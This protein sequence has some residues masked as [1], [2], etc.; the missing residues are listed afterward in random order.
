MLRSMMTPH[1]SG[2]DILASGK[3]IAPVDVVNEAFVDRLTTQLKSTYDYVLLDLP[4]NWSPWFYAAA[5]QSSALLTIV[6][7]SVKSADGSRRV[8]QGLSDLGIL[9]P[10][11]IPIANRTDKTP[12]MKRRIQ[13]ITDILG[14][15]CDLLIR[16]DARTAMAASD[17]GE[18]AREVSAT[19]PLTLDL[20]AI[21]MR[22]ASA[23]AAPA[24]TSSM[25]EGASRFR[26]FG[27]NT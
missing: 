2:F 9:A 3:S 18:C 25:R 1:K 19:A 21:A 15:P 11:L 8:V 26:L 23:R 12:D 16:D 6:E 14:T 20:E 5:K 24:T 7:P 4:M 22:L 27:R 13:R 17:L 10:R